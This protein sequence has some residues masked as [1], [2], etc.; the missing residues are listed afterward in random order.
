M[1]FLKSIKITILT[2]LLTQGY[3]LA[4]TETKAGNGTIY[5]PLIVQ[6]SASSSSPLKWFR[7]AMMMAD[8]Y[9]GNTVGVDELFISG[10][11][12]PSEK[13]WNAIFD[14][15]IKQSSSKQKPVFV[16]DLR[17]ESH[18]YLN[19]LPITLVS[20]HDWINKGKSNEQSLL[21]QENWLHSLNAQK[22]IA[23]VLSKHQ[24]KAKEY[25]SGK[26]ITVKKIQ[27]EEDL[28]S[29]LGFVYHRLYITDHMAPGGSE[30]D[31]FLAIII[32]APKNAWFHMHCRGGKGRTTT[33]LVMYDMLR[34][35]DKVRFADIIARNASIPPYYNLLEVH[36]RNSFFTP[37]YEQRLAFLS[38]FYR[39][40]QHR[41]KGYQGTW[42]EW[43]GSFLI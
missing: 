37:Y 22:K 2:F 1:T 16:L 41:L 18:G 6:D 43:K 13:G 26:T 12:E 8:H 24:F 40:A 10:S 28:V 11:K 3:V 4:Q 42:S 25:S 39:F 27:N 5:P 19:G 20:E 29:R 31:S 17:H 35:A 7:K 21:D 36:R 38:S 32:N 15:I 9:Q 33:F 14:A 23:G 34:N 30:V